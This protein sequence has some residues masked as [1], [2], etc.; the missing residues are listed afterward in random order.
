MY[1]SASS[2][3]CGL[4]CLLTMAATAQTIELVPSNSTIPDE[5]GFSADLSGQRAIIGA[6]EMEAGEGAAYIFEQSSGAWTEVAILTPP[7]QFFTDQFGYSVAMDGDYAAIGQPRGNSLVTRAGAGF[8]FVRSGGTWVQQAELLAADAEVSDFMG[9]AIAISG[10]YVVI[11]A[12]EEDDNGTNA[13]AAYVFERSGTTW[14]EIAKLTASDGGNSDR[15]GQSVAIFGDRIAVGAPRQDAGGFQRGAVYL[16]QL[17]GGVWVEE[18]KLTAFDGSNS[19]KFGNSLSLKGDDLLI[20]SHEHDLAASTF[21]NGAAYVF[22]NSGGTWSV[23]AKLTASDAGTLDRFGHAVD[24]EGDTAIIG[25]LGAGAAYVFERNG[26]TWSELCRIVP[27]GIAPTSELGSAVAKSDSLLL[28]A[29]QNGNQP[30]GNGYVVGPD[31]CDPQVFPVVWQGLAAT[32]TARGVE[33][34]WHTASEQQNQG[35]AIERRA[36]REGWHRVGW[37]PGQGDQTD[38]TRYTFLDTQPLSARSYYRLRQVDFDGGYQFSPIVEVAP[39]MSR[40]SRGLQVFPNPTSGST[41]LRFYSEGTG[42]ATV[43]LSDMAG[44]VKQR[45]SYPL[46]AGQNVLT[47][48]LQAMPAGSYHLRL[49]AAERFEQAL[50]IRAESR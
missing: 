42:R 22:V 8:V 45:A 24:I 47:L 19:D 7:A 36:D 34:V 2:L 13:G 43:T 5:F 27:N 15:F 3:L 23:Q 10:N 17:D 50:I 6:P 20:G 33:L 39:L 40:L 28:V 44:R 48:D 32:R 21:D 30:V 14:T 41:T 9:G 12:P 11:G 16:F 18:A 35:F 25:A 46:V 26:T 49:Q 4:L 38:L 1:P 31:L 37:Q 29:D